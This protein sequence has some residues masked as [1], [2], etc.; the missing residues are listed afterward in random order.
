MVLKKFFQKRWF[1]GIAACA[2]IFVFVVAAGFIGSLTPGFKSVE[3]SASENTGDLET[4]A[5]TS[6]GDIGDSDLMLSESMP[7]E[8]ALDAE[9]KGIGGSLVSG[10]GTD[11]SKVIR[12]ANIFLEVTQLDKVYDQVIKIAEDNQGYLVSSSTYNDDTGNVVGGEI[13]IRVEASKLDGVLEELTGLG[14]LKNREIY[15][16]DVTLQ[17]VDLEARLKQYQQQKE[18]LLKLYQ[19]N[20]DISDLIQIEGEML[21]VQTELDSL[22]AQFKYLQEVTDFATVNIHLEVP[23]MYG[24]SLSSVHWD[25]L[26]T[27]LV[28]GLIAGINAFLGGVAFFLVGFFYLLPL[29]IIV[30]IALLIYYF[31][32]RR[33]RK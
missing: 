22:T 30:V 23:A 2:T 25:N 7:Q 12:S 21:R 15:G 10:S 4:P 1:K 6:A 31:I 28:S 19:E 27:K 13:L 3:W 11:Q 18:R 5:V 32:K 17:Y 9:T 29:I 16:E 8:A 33:N 24:Q 20:S 26:G 14:S